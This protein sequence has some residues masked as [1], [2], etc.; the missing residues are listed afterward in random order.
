MK[1]LPC[2]LWLAFVAAPCLPIFANSAVTYLDR[3]KIKNA[4]G[5]EFLSVKVYEQKVKLEYQRGGQGVT[6]EAPRAAVKGKRKYKAGEGVLA[7]VKMADDG[8]KV[9]SP[10]GDL[11]WKVKVTSEKIKISDNEEGLNP[12]ELKIYQKDGRVKVSKD[13]K[14]L[15]ELKAYPDRGEQKLK[16]APSNETMFELK[17]KTLSPMLAVLALEAIPVDQRMMLAAELAL[18]EMK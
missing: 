7:E 12:Y 8:F 9:R 16:A 5:E 15:A 13:G 18:L 2:L 6:L 3:Y 10:E 11:H 4:K 14:V 17:R 1:I